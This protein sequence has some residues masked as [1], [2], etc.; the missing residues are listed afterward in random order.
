VVTNVSTE[1]EFVSEMHHLGATHFHAKPLGQ[2]S[3]EAL[4]AKLRACLERAG[5]AS[6]EAC[7]KLVRPAP[8]REGA[9]AKPA[10]GPRVRIDGTRERARY[11][12]FID[13]AR[14]TMQEGAMVPLLRASAAHE[15]SPGAWSSR[16]SLYLGRS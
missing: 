6:H 7:A 10:V 1:P 13:D 11:V 5:R 8:R 2:A 3:G 15:R 4:V 16:Q 9:A 12:L 14:E